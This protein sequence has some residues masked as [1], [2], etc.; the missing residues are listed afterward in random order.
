VELDMSRIWFW[1]SSTANGSYSL[2]LMVEARITE[3]APPSFLPPVALYIASEKI[4]GG[5]IFKLTAR[6]TMSRRGSHGSHRKIHAG[7]QSMVMQGEVYLG[8]KRGVRIGAHCS[9]YFY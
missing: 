4:K 9:R 5:W 1:G 2:W 3:L 6:T 7:S 8:Q